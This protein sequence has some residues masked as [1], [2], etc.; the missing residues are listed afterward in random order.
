M[1]T[2]FLYIVAFI[3]CATSAMAQTSNWNL[4]VQG[5]IHATDSIIAP[6][7]LVSSG[8]TFGGQLQANSL[9]TNTIY[10]I[11]S[12]LTLNTNEVRVPGKI[13][14]TEIIVNTTGADFVFDK[15]YMLRSLD[16]V[17]SYIEEHQ[18]LPEVPSARQ[19][20]ED[21]M[22]VDQMVVKLLQKV[23]ELTLYTIQQEERIREL[24]MNIK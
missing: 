22:S 15:D 17:R 19:M 7:L 21:G 3:I 23:E 18:H 16:E 4:N 14:A 1:K 12:Y 13:K 9:L 24:E 8:A 11:G 5:K 6:S 2:R 20:Q 10:P